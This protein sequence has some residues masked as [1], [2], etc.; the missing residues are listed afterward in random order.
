MRSISDKIMSRYPFDDVT[1]LIKALLKFPSSAT[2]T[3][4]SWLLITLRYLKAN[5]FL[6]E[7]N[8]SIL[9]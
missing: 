8:F 7:S 3:I 9:S 2:L 6:K 4:K 1:V 5:T